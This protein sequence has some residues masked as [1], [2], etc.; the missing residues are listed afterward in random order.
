[1]EG[2]ARR[3]S[4]SRE[5]RAGYRVHYNLPLH[6]RGTDTSG[7]P[8]SSPARSQILTRDGGLIVCPL[9]LTPGARV[10]LIHGE[11]QARVRIVAAV[12]VADDSTAYGVAFVDSLIQDFW[13]IHLSQTAATGVGCTVL[14][15]SL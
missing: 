13:G 5:Q 4:K 1:M 14:E 11:K 9:S 7:K 3:M 6:L 10:I 2:E 8:F 12:R 15:C